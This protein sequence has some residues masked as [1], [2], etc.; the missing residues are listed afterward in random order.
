[1]KS[2]IVSLLFACV[3]LASVEDSEAQGNA[4]IITSL[5]CKVKM[6]LTEL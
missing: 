6:D 5:L 2:L 1:M 3:L 4:V